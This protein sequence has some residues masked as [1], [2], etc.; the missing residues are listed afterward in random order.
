[1]V[2]NSVYVYVDVAVEVGLKLLYRCFDKGFGWSCC[3]CC[4]NRRTNAHTVNKYADLYSGPEHLMHFRYA[5]ILNTLFITFFYGM[6]LPILFPI[7]AFT[8]WNL[9]IVDKIALTYVFVEPPCY[10]DK[11]NTH[12]L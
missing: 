7:A 5:T 2:I 8:F 9:Y 3:F 4:K 1:M 10:N 12:A 6:A 11:L